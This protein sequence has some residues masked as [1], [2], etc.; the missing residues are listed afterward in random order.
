MKCFALAYFARIMPILSWVIPIDFEMVFILWFRLGWILLDRILDHGTVAPGRL[1]ICRINLEL[2][3]LKTLKSLDDFLV[4]FI[5]ILNEDVTLLPKTVQNVIRQT[6]RPAI[7][8]NLSS[9]WIGSFRIG[10]IFSYC[11][12]QKLISR[13]R[14]FPGEI[15]LSYVIEEV[16]NICI[17]TIS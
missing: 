14:S 2:L 10:E 5:T 8:E 12:T 17:G 13:N 1:T 7:S 16:E 4:Y 3:Y 9:I 11:F 6:L 15:N